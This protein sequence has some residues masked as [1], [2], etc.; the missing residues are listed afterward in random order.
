MPLRKVFRSVVSKAESDLLDGLKE[1]N[2][3]TPA[4]G[5][6]Y[7]SS[8]LIASI[9]V[10]YDRAFQGRG[11][12]RMICVG[13]LAFGGLASIVKGA[14]SRRRPLLQSDV[15]NSEKLAVVDSEC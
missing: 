14:T 5:I 3:E 13:A 7:G 1:L 10:Q 6:L 9:G 15:E 2:P 12:E 11:V 8:W 4:E